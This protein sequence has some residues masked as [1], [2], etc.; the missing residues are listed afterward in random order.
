MILQSDRT[1]TG[2]RKVSVFPVNLFSKLGSS[3]HSSFS[4]GLVLTFVFISVSFKIS[5]FLCPSQSI[6][7]L[8]M[9]QFSSILIPSF[10]KKLAIFQQPLQCFQ[11]SN[12]VELLHAIHCACN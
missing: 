11:T 1:S 7:F 5:S 12:K 4:S 9:F 3:V 2:W 10:W 6:C 8:S